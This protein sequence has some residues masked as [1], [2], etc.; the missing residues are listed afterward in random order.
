MSNFHSFI[1]GIV[2]GLTE[3]L[4]ISSTGHIILFSKI[5]NISEP[6]IFYDL[7]LHLGTLIAVFIIF[8][9]FIVKNIKNFKLIFLIL[10]SILS[11]GLFYILFKEPLESFFSN[12]KFIPIFFLIT[13]FYL[14]FFY[15]KNKRTKTI[16][17]ITIL[18]SIIIGLSQGFSILPGISRSGFTFITATLLG[19]KE[20][21]AFKY[22]FLLSIPT[23]LGS[24][25]LK[26][27]DYIK[28]PIK[29]SA[30]SLLLGFFA[31]LIF[32]VISIILF[33][34]SIH[35]RNLK[36]FS[37]YLIIIS[38]IIIIWFW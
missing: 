22:S 7:F 25:I 26:Y 35:K 37:F 10:I 9:P 13:S 8:S 14:F 12:F 1:L 17:D 32:G 23:I 19:I 21:D 18:D 30:D 6:P 27:F 4:P 28:S 29:I 34:S 20:D 5:L 16:K 11:T 2:Q 38:I 24:T 36:I 33:R 3:F 31:S 15:F